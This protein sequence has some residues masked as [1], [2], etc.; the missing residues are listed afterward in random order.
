MVV[1]RIV[2]ILVIFRFACWSKN[3]KNSVSFEK[4]TTKQMFQTQRGVEVE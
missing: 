1:V 3:I 4:C 2:R